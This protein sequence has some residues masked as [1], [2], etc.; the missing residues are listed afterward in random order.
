MSSPSSSS[1]ALFVAGDAFFASRRAQF[2]T[3]TARDRIPTT[4]SLREF[5]EA[6]GLMSHGTDIADSVRQV[7]VHR[8]C[9]LLGKADMTFCGGHVRF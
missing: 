1:H 5:V 7:G 3:L 6:G 4:Y 8:T 2:V 9:P